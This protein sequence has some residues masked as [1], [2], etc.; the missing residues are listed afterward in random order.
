[1]SVCPYCK[2]TLK[3]ELGL[4]IHLKWCYE[5]MKIEEGEARRKE[6]ELRRI[7]G[8]YL[9]WDE[10]DLPLEERV[11]IA[12]E[13][14]LE[15]HE[16][17]PPMYRCELEVEV[18]S[19]VE[20]LLGR[21]ENVL[22]CSYCRE[23]LGLDE[24]TDEEDWRKVA[25]NESYCKFRWE[26]DIETAFNIDD[27]GAVEIEYCDPAV[28]VIECPELEVRAKFNGLIVFFRS[29]DEF[30]WIAGVEGVDVRRKA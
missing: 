18:T 27:F 13:R 7:S 1:M 6:E 9:R 4:K 30:V 2:K 26:G 29:A 11:R 8:G 5:K 3:N 16:R 14:C 25:D 24:D 28:L 10:L 22:E 20:K 15:E 17:A 21:R 12:V 23:E 19:L